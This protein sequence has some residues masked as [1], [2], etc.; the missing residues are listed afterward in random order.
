MSSIAIQVASPFVTKKRYAEM[1]GQSM[2]A[3]NQAV[4]SGKL[5]IMPK[6]SSKSAVLIN[7]VALYKKADE[8]RYV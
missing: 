1:T 5:P 3:I 6:E 4:A 8:Q 2:G 7:M